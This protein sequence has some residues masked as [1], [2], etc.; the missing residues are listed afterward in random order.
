MKR[1]CLAIYRNRTVTAARLE[2][3]FYAIWL[4]HLKQPNKMN[5]LIFFCYE[6]NACSVE[7]NLSYN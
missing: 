7:L 5:K 3:K 4:M 1:L 6:K 2:W